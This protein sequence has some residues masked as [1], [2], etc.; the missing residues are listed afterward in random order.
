[1]RFFSYLKILSVFL[2]F[3]T[4]WLQNCQ[5]YVTISLVGENSVPDIISLI[6]PF[7]SYLS[8]VQP[9]V[10]LRVPRSIPA[11]HRPLLRRGSVRI[12]AGRRARAAGGRGHSRR[13]DRWEGIDYF[14]L[15]GW[16]RLINQTR[17]AKVFFFG[18]IIL[19][20]VRYYDYA[21]QQDLE[22]YTELL[23]S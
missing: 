17:A 22:V 9:D 18:M 15:L 10:L 5:N 20:S 8:R 4:F 7:I 19:L 11:G 3:H 1:M 21:M 14:R 23:K 13:W 2:L 12:G 6:W 16:Q